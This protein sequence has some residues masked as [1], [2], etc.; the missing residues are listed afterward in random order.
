[1]ADDATACCW[2]GIEEPQSRYLVEFTFQES[3]ILVAHA[4]AEAARG[5]GVGVHEGESF[6]KSDSIA[7]DAAKLRS[8]LIEH[9]PLVLGVAGGVRTALEIPV[10][11]RKLRE[12]I[13]PHL[14]SARASSA[15]VAPSSRRP[16]GYFQLPH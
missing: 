3:E 9:V 8:V 12:K 10:T 2:S 6:A 1:V 16:F 7:D 14:E 11:I 15:V 5:A 13:R 4:L